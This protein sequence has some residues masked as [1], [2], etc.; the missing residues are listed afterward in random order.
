M[1]ELKASAYTCRLTTEA[2]DCSIVLLM[3]ILS[4]VS[5]PELYDASCSS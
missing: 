5:S 4:N 1:T 2:G 3:G